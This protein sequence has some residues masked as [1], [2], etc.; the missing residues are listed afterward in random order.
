MKLLTQEKYLNTLKVKICSREK[1]IYQSW[2]K[3]LPKYR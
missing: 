1:V 2:F 3:I